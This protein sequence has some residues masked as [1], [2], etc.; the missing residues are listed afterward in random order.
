MAIFI[1]TIEKILGLTQPIRLI[2]IDNTI[3]IVWQEDINQSIEIQIA[4]NS[5][6]NGVT[7]VNHC[8]VNT[9]NIFATKDI[10]LNEKIGNYVLHC[11]KNGTEIAFYANPL[12]ESYVEEKFDAVNNAVQSIDTT[13]TAEKVMSVIENSSDSTVFAYENGGKLYFQSNKQEFIMG[14]QYTDF[15]LSWGFDTATRFTGLINSTAANTT[16]TIYPYNYLLPEFEQLNVITEP[17]TDVILG[18]VS[19]GAVR[20]VEYWTANTNLYANLYAGQFAMNIDTSNLD[21]DFINVRFSNCVVAA[22][23]PSFVNSTFGG[24]FF[25]TTA[26]ATSKKQTSCFR[27][28]LNQIPI[29]AVPLT[30]NSIQS[31]ATR[32]MLKMDFFV[33]NSYFLFCEKF[34]IPKMHNYISATNA[35]LWGNGN[36]DLSFG[37]TMR[38]GEIYNVYITQNSPNLQTL[39]TTQNINIGEEIASQDYALSTAFTLRII[40]NIG[41]PATLNINYNGQTTTLNVNS[42]LF[43]VTDVACS[44]QRASAGQPW[45]LALSIPKKLSNTTYYDWVVN[46]AIQADKA[47]LMKY[48]TATT[49]LTTAQYNAFSTNRPI[50]VTQ[51]LNAGDTFII[52]NIKCYYL[53]GN[54]VYYTTASGTTVAYQTTQYSDN[55]VFNINI[56]NIA[57]APTLLIVKNLSFLNVRPLGNNKM[58]PLTTTSTTN[59]PYSNGSEPLLIKINNQV[60]LRETNTSYYYDSSFK[61]KTISFKRYILSVSGVIYTVAAPVYSAT[62][63][64]YIKAGNTIPLENDTVFLIDT[65]RSYLD[66]NNNVAFGTSAVTSTL[67]FSVPAPING[68]LQD[69]NILTK[70]FAIT[71]YAS[72]GSV[73]NIF[74][75]PSSMTNYESTRFKITQTGN[76]LEQRYSLNEF[77]LEVIITSSYANSKWTVDIQKNLKPW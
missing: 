66:T 12:L 46:S 44:Y 28:K 25:G 54:Y 62:Q 34:E 16:S 20:A 73:T 31:S 35:N 52:E 8:M 53:R 4:L 75:I 42:D 77:Y 40:V 1:F 50:R 56:A 10:E 3:Y 2:D 14:V 37:E 24:T 38:N 23:S 64:K 5:T 60:L 11:T 43:F 67:L 33:S 70:G 55:C 51:A 18:S 57:S 9:D 39:P 15:A 49:A 45:R 61:E 76:V 29:I 17:K 6:A 47:N 21:D 59:R 41:V 36:I 13:I 7:T 48:S 72:V 30:T 22:A 58:F 32:Q 19:F 26:Q 65:D 69:S 27:V 68:Y 74:T 71:V 63:Y